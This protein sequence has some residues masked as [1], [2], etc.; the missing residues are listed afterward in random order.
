M[1][2]LGLPTISLGVLS[3]SFLTSIS[4]FAAPQR[5]MVLAGPDTP[6]F[7]DVI[8]SRYLMRADDTLSE[9]QL[10][11]P[12]AEI[13]DA[14]RHPSKVIDFDLPDSVRGGSLIQHV[15]IDWNRH[16]HDPE[17]VY[18]KP[19]FDFHF[20]F[21]DGAK[22]ASINCSDQTAIPEELVPAGYVLPPLDAPD[23]CVP[24]MGY[25]AVPVADLQPSHAFTETPI[26]GYYQG[27]FIFF[28]PM[29]TREFLMQGKSI[30]YPIQYPA[31]FLKQSKKMFMPT[32]FKMEFSPKEDAYRITLGY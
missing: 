9:I 29:M 11:I 20:F 28:E 23:S 13:E 14:I 19:H 27:Q 17:K 24:N 30:N 26:Y 7:G 31:S 32:L 8:E 10:K 6:L 22:V 15:S 18:G 16:G 5:P 12:M 4:L 3:C 21:V 1:L 2:H 25:H